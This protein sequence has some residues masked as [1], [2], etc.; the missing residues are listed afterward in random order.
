[1]GWKDEG[2]GGD[3][4]V[5]RIWSDLLGFSRMQGVGTNKLWL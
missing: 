1:M 2:R 5:T 3:K 4:K